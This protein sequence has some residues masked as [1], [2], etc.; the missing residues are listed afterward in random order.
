M[1]ALR[2]A[3]IVMGVLIVAGVVVLAVALAQKFGT[4]ASL[5]GTAAAIPAL[6]E[7][8]GTRIAGTSLSGERLVL[9]L[10]GGGPDRVVVFDLARGRV[11]GRVTLA[12]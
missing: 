5:G 2:A 4:A 12:R 1:K 10:T 6:D 7:P 3:V 11:T 9:Q 8:A